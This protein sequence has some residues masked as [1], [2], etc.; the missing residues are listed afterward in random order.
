MHKWEQN[1]GGAAL[2]QKKRTRA[3]QTKRNRQE[4]ERV[5]YWRNLR[6]RTEKRVK[7]AEARKLKRMGDALQSTNSTPRVD[8]I[9][10]Q[11][12]QNTLLGRLFSRKR[13]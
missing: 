5:A 11:A 3:E 1:R 13:G 10:N 12:R 8:T 6:K 7:D 2:K 4:N 9:K